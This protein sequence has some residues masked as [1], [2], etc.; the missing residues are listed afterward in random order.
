MG[1]LSSPQQGQRAC[2]L[3]PLS[4]SLATFLSEARGASLDNANKLWMG[5][6]QGASEGRAAGLPRR[7]QQKK[8]PTL[9]S[10]F[11]VS[12]SCKLLSPPRHNTK[13]QKPP[14]GRCR[15]LRA[16]ADWVVL[17]SVA[18]GTI[19]RLGESVVHPLCTSPRQERQGSS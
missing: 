2:R 16:L 18:F 14:P 15:S 13:V 19:L 10:T 7:E 1:L 17:E 8:V 9:L 5:L 12:P 3:F 4:C 11:F 6:S